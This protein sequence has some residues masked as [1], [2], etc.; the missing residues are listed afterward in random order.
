MKRLIF[1]AAV[2]CTCAI[3]AQKPGPTPKPAPVSIH[4]QG[5]VTNGIEAGCLVVRDQS[6]GTLYNLLISGARP[7]VGE[8]IEFTGSP[9]EGPQACMQGTPINVSSWSQ[10][11]AVKCTSQSTPA[12]GKGF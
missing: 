5:C 11:D 8:G 6:S 4:G 12:P 9:H 2:A 7:R 1:A 3:C 10:N